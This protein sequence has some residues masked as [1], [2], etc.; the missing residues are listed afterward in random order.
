MT[1]NKAD[2]SDIGLVLSIK[3]TT[4]NGDEYLFSSRNVSNYKVFLEHAE[5][6]NTLIKGSHVTLQAVSTLNGDEPQLVKA[7]VIEITNEGI[8]LRFIL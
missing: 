4:E 1:I 5:N 2:P 7:E 8:E 3:L 6:S